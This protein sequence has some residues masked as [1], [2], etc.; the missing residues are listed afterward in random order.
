MPPR[1]QAGHQGAEDEPVLRVAR[2]Q[3]DGEIEKRLELGQEL[4][5]RPLQ[6][7]TRMIDDVRALGTDFRTWD[8]LNDRLLRNRFTTP[9]V[10]DEYKRVTAGHVGELPSLEEVGW[11]RDNISAQM[12]KLSSI[13]LQLELYES[14]ATED[15]TS[16]PLAGAAA[17]SKI[18]VVHGHDGEVKLQVAEFIE[19][20]VGERPIIL[21]EKAASGSRTVIEKFE[22]YASQ[23][24]FAVVLLT[25]DDVGSA[26]GAATLNDRARQN[27]VLEL[28]FFF[29]KLGRSR[30]VALYEDGVELPSDISGVLYIPLTGNW[31]TEL[32][33]EVRAAGI[34]IDPGKLF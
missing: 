4:L 31:H 12:R 10:A 3:L 13:R 18:F 5:D 29:G 16:P 23:A 7:G 26:K 11:T 19:R 14:E 28:G 8:E 30:V 24:G 6:F 25:A 33:K 27:V 22:S 9:K 2:S 34:V 21:H 15:N 20:I 32:A 17:G 1:R